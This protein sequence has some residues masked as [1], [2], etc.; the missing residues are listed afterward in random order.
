MRTIDTRPASRVGLVSLFSLMASAAMAQSIE[1]TATYRERM[2]LPAGAV[3][4]AVLEDVS[5]ADAPAETIAQTRIPSPGNPP[6]A[7]TIA[8]APG[9]IVA[10]RRYNVRA[11]ILVD[12]KVLF[13]TDIATP[14]LAGGSPSK[15]S[16]MMRRVGGAQTPPPASGGT[17][18]LEGTYWRA[19]ELAGKPTPQ[20]HPKREAHLQFQAGR[21]SGSDGC[22][23]MT[24]T[25]QLKG[26]QLT[27]GQ[28]AATQMACLKRSGTEGPIREALKNTSRFTIAGDR[29]VLFDAGGTRVAAFVA[30]S[31]ASSGAPASGL[32]GTSWQLVKFEGSDDTTLTPD[33]RAKYT[34]E[35]G[36]NGQVTARIDCNT[37]RGTWKS[38]GSNQ[39]QFGPLALTRA[40]CPVGSLHD[41]IVKQ[42]GNI[43]SYVLRDGHLFFALMADGGIYEFEP[44]LKVK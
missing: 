29:L 14:V 21:V 35:F 19:S 6:I 25:Y 40:K 23:R 20:Q 28:M 34:I 3:F 30:G 9:K 37:G 16:L 12:D 42:W 41:Q 39:L 32:A 36:A 33:D 13:A 22:N 8:Y 31:Q 10:G 7:F 43:R 38:S 17:K 4:E 2:A 27:F 1:G 24:G 15:V 5:R 11:R 44:V 26:D 18:P